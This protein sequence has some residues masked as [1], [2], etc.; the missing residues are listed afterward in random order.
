MKLKF[1]IVS[2]FFYFIMQRKK[3][4]HI[5]IHFHSFKLKNCI[6]YGK[7]IEKKLFLGGHN[8]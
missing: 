2:V 7:I 3:N 8:K 5:W 6:K 4:A 1:F